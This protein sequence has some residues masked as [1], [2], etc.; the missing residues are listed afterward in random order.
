MQ[1]GG[2]PLFSWQHALM[3]GSIL[4]PFLIFWM[5][6]RRQSEKHHRE[7]IDQNTQMHH[8]NQQRLTT[9]ETRLEPIWDWWNRNRGT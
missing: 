2:D 3:V 5:D 4:V 8:E 7:T 6:G 1:S 9:I